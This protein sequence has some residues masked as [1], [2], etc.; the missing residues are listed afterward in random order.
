MPTLDIQLLGGFHLS[1]EDAPAIL[2][3]PREQRLLAYLLLHR[4][5]P[6]PREEGAFLLWPDSTEKQAR[7]NLR[8]SIRLLKQGWPEGQ[9]HLVDKNGLLQWK[10]V[11]P[12]ALD[13]EQMEAALAAAKQSRQ[14]TAQRWHLQQAIDRYR[15]PLLPACDDEWLKTER[16]RLE[17]LYEEALIALLDLLE[18][19][20]DYQTAIHYAQRL[21]HHD[22]LRE[23]TY[24]HLMRLHALNGDRAAALNVYRQ[25]QQTL[26]DELAVA[27]SP[28]TRTLHEQIRDAGTLAA[29]PVFDS[30]QTEQ[31]VGRED[32]WRRLHAAWQRS[33]RGRAQLMVIAGA[34]GIG[35]TRLAEELLAW[36]TRLGMV[37]ARTRSYA[38]EGDLPY[39]PLAALLRAEPL[40]RAWRDLDDVWLAEIASIV[41]E[42]SALLADSAQLVGERGQRQRFFE[43]LARAFAAHTKPLLLL[44]DDL[45]WCDGDTLECLHYLLRFNA[46]APFLIVG[47]VRPGE[48]DAKHPLSAVLLSLR[49]E[50]RLGE[51]ELAPLD[52]VETVAL[53]EQTAASALDAASQ[54]HIVA[55]SEG[56]PF[57]V[58]EMI[59]V[60]DVEPSETRVAPAPRKV[61]AVIQQRLQQL[62]QSAQQL[63]RLAA[64]VG[65]SFTLDVLAA[66]GEWDDATLA[67]LVEEL[68]QRRIV[69]EQAVTGY[70]FSH[71]LL[72][73]VAYSTTSGARR[74]LL[75]ARVSA[76]LEQ[77]A[78]TEAREI[79]A[80]LGH[81]HEHAGHADRAIDYYVSAAEYSFSRH[82]FREVAH[83]YARALNVF[84]STQ[85]AD[86]PSEEMLRRELGLQSGL[87]LALMAGS[88]HAE[89]RILTAL[90]RALELSQLLN[91]P[92]VSASSLH[93]LWASY[94]SMGKLERAEHFAQ[95][96]LRLAEEEGNL[97]AELGAHYALAQS[98]L[99][100]GRFQ[101]T[102]DHMARSQAIYR[103]ELG[104]ACA[105]IYGFDS[106]L[107]IYA[108][109]AIATWV[110]GY[111]TQ[112]QAQ[113]EHALAAIQREATPI[114]QA[115]VAGIGATVYFLRREPEQ[116]LRQTQMTIDICQQYD[117]PLYAAHSLIL[118][119][120]ARVHLGDTVA[121]K[122]AGADEARRGLENWLAIGARLA[123][124]LY[125]VVLAE[126]SLQLGQLRESLSL[127]EQAAAF[128]AENGDRLVAAEI[129][130][131]QGEVLRKV[132]GP[133]A[134]VEEHF[135]RAIAIARTQRAKSYE[136]RACLGLARLWRQQGQARAACELLSPVYAWF[137]EGFDT[138]DLE[139][140]GSLLRALSPR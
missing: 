54:A 70:D 52:K 121:E 108:D 128:A 40:R 64:V 79:S 27:P 21:L 33:R 125:H 74:R 38:A 97:H 75:H 49:R 140:A 129:P 29:P 91:E 56:N 10:P 120:W 96:L 100:A 133:A 89:P 31:L 118:H 3:K 78:A 30:S 109:S 34:A 20:R 41:P 95:Q 117:L 60:Q 72:R 82:A 101:L 66:A 62:S 13:V 2:P 111:P 119:G 87:S 81:H 12:I 15:G 98:Y 65:R 63:V 67:R 16:R 132:G 124:P 127:L 26:R 14:V 102:V 36:A 85:D 39:G 77:A 136:L 130:R 11:K 94:I 76:A 23:N 105:A 47:T 114:T 84:A 58:V 134:E 28:A 126:V 123:L 53:A 51:I 137:T 24:Q 73:E 35:K 50:G 19:E 46:S 107:T 90:H 8:K 112:A 106:G 9:A 17:Q 139:E 86:A 7:T 69:R 55:A 25:C 44:L 122:E 1:G 68:L 5:A 104:A 99:F 22:D 71:D 45:Q 92:E 116:T 57:F 80:Q 42:A 61:Y 6:Q 48:V 18:R 37:T 110:R 138:P 93:T 103:P 135:Q 113:A 115:F 32:E 83:L 59:R 4:H 88:L 131:L 43:A